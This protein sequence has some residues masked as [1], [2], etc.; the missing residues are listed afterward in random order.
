MHTAILSG[1]RVVYKAWPPKRGKTKPGAVADMR[2][3]FAW[4]AQS[5]VYSI[6]EDKAFAL[7]ITTG[8]MYYPRDALISAMY[9][10]LITVRTNDGQTWWSK[11]LSTKNIQLMLDEI[12]NIPG[13]MLMRGGDEWIG[14]FPGVANYILQTNGP[15]VM[16]TWVPN[17]GGGGG[18]SGA[19]WA[20][21]G[22]QNGP[23]GS[24]HNY[25]GSVYTN[26]VDTT[27][28][29]VWAL[30]N[31]AAAR[32]YHAEIWS[33]G[34]STLS[35]LLGQSDSVMVAHA[36]DQSTFFAFDPPVDIPAGQKFAI[37]L[38][39]EGQGATNTW[40]SYY[41]TN[42]NLG[43]PGKDFGDNITVSSAV[44]APGDS[45]A[46]SGNY[47]SIAYTGAPASP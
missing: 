17:T 3:L 23:D 46:L 40:L 35:A 24:G 6:A 29:Q 37:M 26:F 25:K 38:M 10:T 18:G 42:C 30:L 21:T 7:E 16:P 28:A 12:T 14:L 20:Q 15:G 13:A 31:P 8:S 33:L 5:S 41:G 11:R 1:G 36:A 45:Y 9:G 39:E 2:Q 44:A 32:T 4:A 22:G 19:F 43:V 34:T 47:Y 27:V